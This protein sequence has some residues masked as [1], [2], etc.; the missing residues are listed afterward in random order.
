MK[1]NKINNRSRKKKNRL[2]GIVIAVLLAMVSLF[3]LPCLISKININSQY[4]EV[5]ISSLSSYLGGILGGMVSGTLAF[6]GVFYTIRY[7]KKTDEQRERA[8]VMPFLMLNYTPRD[9]FNPKLSIKLGTIYNDYLKKNYLIRVENIGNGFARS[10][11]IVTEEHR[12]GYSFCDVIP[13]NTSSYFVFCAQ[14]G[15][16]SN[17]CHFY[18]Q[19]VDSKNNKYQ[20]QYCAFFSTDDVDIRC[21]PPELLLGSEG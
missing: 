16:F 11:S 10:I 7:Y 8:G 19:Y 1:I 20:Q 5:W 12:A 13:V 14:S 15:C 21:E 17:Y 18:I 9:I 3:L 6:L 2:I 4:E